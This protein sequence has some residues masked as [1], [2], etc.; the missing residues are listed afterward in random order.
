MYKI[1]VAEDD[2]FLM[3]IYSDTLM[4]EGFEVIPTTNGVEVLNKVKLTTPD[5]I[6][7]DLV[8]PIKDGFETLEELKLD[9]KTKKIPV[10]ILTNLGQEEDIKRGKDLGAVDYLVKSDLSIKEIIDKVKTYLIKTRR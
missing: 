10:I 6:L 3:K 2:R 7:L 4:R 1:L 9:K 8:M 5:L